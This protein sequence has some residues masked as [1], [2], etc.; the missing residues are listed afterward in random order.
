[1]GQIT[2]EIDDAL[3]APIFAQ[4]VEVSV[5]LPCLNEHETLEVCIRKAEAALNAA[6]LRGPHAL[7]LLRAAETWLRRLPLGGQ[8]MMLCQRLS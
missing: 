1:M 3:E 6:G 8:Y 4:T 7:R 5:V 2:Q